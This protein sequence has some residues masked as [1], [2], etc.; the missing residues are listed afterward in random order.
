[1][2]CTAN[3]NNFSK[4]RVKGWRLYLRKGFT[5]DFVR[6]LCESEV[7]TDGVRGPFESIPSSRFCRVTKSVVSFHGG[8][9]KLYLKEYFY[10]SL[11]DVIKHFFR[12]SRAERAFKAAMMLEQNNFNSPEVI[13]L[14]LLKKGP[15]CSKS[16]L[17]TRQ[18]EQ[19]KDIPG[20]LYEDNDNLTGQGLSSKQLFIRS[21]GETIGRMHATGIVHG[22]LRPR[23]ILA[24]QNANGWRFFLLDNERTKKCLHLPT[25]SRVRNL[26][27]INMFGPEKVGRTDRMRFFESYCKASHIKPKQ[28]KILARIVTERTQARLRQ[29]L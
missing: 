19:V 27:Q 26:V 10:R 5:R 20:R 6:D 13:T 18:L 14:G 15:F 2:A 1:M 11:W 3:Y 16:F 22:D 28:A 9:H 4:I 29:Q 7:L 12:P 21:L 23:N 8:C 17:L 25:K 24:Q